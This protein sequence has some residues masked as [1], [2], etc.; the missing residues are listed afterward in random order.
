VRL[1][2]LRGVLVALGAL[3]IG[4][5]ALGAARD[6]DLS[7]PGVLLFLAAVLVG[8]DAVLMPAAI[9][10]GALVG[11][12]VPRPARAAV[13]AGLLVTAALGA[14]AVPLLAGFGR[15]ADNPSV[16]PRDYGRGALLAFAL[17]WAA[18]AATWL[19]PR[20]RRGRSRPAPGTTGG[21]QAAEPG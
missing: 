16:L 8:H 21:C 5:G 2:V 7:P 18:T 3:A 4:Y 20:R 13:R 14:L 1:R 12:F 11:R 17:A 6:H 19:L 9:G 10:V 15:A